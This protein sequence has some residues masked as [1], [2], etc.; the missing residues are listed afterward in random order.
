MNKRYLILASVLAFSAPVFAQSGPSG[1]TTG[2]PKSVAPAGSQ[3]AATGKCTGMTSD[4]AGGNPE[5]RSEARP[6]DQKSAKSQKSKAGTDTGT[7]SSA[8]A[9]GTAGSGAA[10]TGAGIGADP[11]AGTKPSAPGQHHQPLK[12]AVRTSKGT[13]GCLLL[14]LYRRAR[15]IAFLRILAGTRIRPL[16]RA[17][18]VCEL[19]V[20]RP[21]GREIVLHAL[22]HFHVPR[23]HFA[24]DVRCK[25]AAE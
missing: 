23:A 17:S 6:E 21:A 16:L 10:T 11:S 13:F 14:V 5:S 4:K 24:Q 7:S 19:V 1:S 8:G 9:G 18:Q 2:G 22:E 25:Q 20:E 12:A 15:R 3:E